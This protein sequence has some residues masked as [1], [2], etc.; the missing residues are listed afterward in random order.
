MF[1][2]DAFAESLTNIS[3][4]PQ[5]SPQKNIQKS[6]I[7]TYPAITVA[8][9]P[10]RPQTARRGRGMAKRGTAIRGRRKAGKNISEFTMKRQKPEYDSDPN[11]SMESEETAESYRPAVK[12]KAI[13]FSP[14]RSSPKAT[15]TLTVTVP[16]PANHIKYMYGVNAWKHWVHAKNNEME[17]KLKNLK[18]RPSNLS[19]LNPDILNS[20]SEELNQ[21]LA[22]LVKLVRKPNGEMYAPDSIYYLCLGKFF[23]S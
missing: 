20:T 14:A 19:R 1:F 10:S 21:G 16:L 11:W 12:K 23:L 22:M 17:N 4:S 5:S 15:S 6:P 2:L 3:D 7:K 8:A 13:E 18:E 9:P